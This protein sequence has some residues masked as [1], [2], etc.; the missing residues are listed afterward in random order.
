MRD[1]IL[2]ISHSELVFNYGPFLVW[3]EFLLGA[4]V[5]ANIYVKRKLARVDIV[6][7]CVMALM[8]F[9]PVFSW[10]IKF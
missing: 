9:V 2:I 4:W 6:I 10:R 3:A 1:T 7:V 8:F 5:V